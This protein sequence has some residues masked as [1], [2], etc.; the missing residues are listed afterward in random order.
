MPTQDQI[1]K[2]LQFDLATKEALRKHDDNEDMVHIIEHHFF[3]DNYSAL[4]GLA[5]VGSMLGFDAGEIQDGRTESGDSYWYFDLLSQAPTYLNHLARE[6]LLMLSLAEAY[7]ADYDG[8][9]TL[10]KKD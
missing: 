3:S 1:Q 2:Q 6:S 10:V 8:W 9:G 5:K 7:G 4:A